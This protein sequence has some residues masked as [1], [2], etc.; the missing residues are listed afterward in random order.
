MILERFMPSRF[1]KCA[2]RC[3]E[4]AVEEARKLGHDT[5]GDDDLLLGVLRDEE[6]DAAEAL[7]SVGVT[8]EAAREQARLLFE[9]ALSS[10]GISLD[11]VI[12]R[13]GETFEFGKPGRGHIPFSPGAKKAL[14]QSLREALALGDRE[15]TP[16]HVLLGVI[17]NHDGA[18]VKLL[19]SLG[20]EVEEVERAVLRG[21]E[22]DIY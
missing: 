3:V 2:R 13:A 17:R 5:V 21:R 14:E 7:R 20:I 8:L 9:D 10:I 1:V 15:I 16:E 12:E 11:E 22:S 6:S 19:G 4:S 18:A